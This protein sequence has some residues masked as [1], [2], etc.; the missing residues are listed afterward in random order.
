[1][2]LSV[3]LDVTFGWRLAMTRPSQKLFEHPESANIL[4]CLRSCNH[5][6]Q[7]YRDFAYRAASPKWANA[8]DL[9]NGKGSSLYGGKWNP[10]GLFKAVY[11]ACN[12]GTALDEALAQNRRNGLP[13]YEALPLVITGVSV[14]LARVLNLTSDDAQKL[15]K[16]SV[17]ELTVEPHGAS[18]IESAGQAIGRLAYSLKYE[19][20]I[21]PSAAAPGQKNLVVFVRP[22]MKRKLRVLNE[23]ELPVKTAAATRKSSGNPS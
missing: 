4:S 20:L 7:P 1:M 11:L 9:L 13:D 14:N 22:G 21:V 15:I 8:E 10:P 6:I 17:A 5:L 19:A 23:E 2:A 12:S 3:Q 18:T 16:R